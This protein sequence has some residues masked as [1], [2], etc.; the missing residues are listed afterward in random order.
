[1][2][3]YLID[4][5]DNIIEECKKKEYVV[6]CKGSLTIGYIKHCFTKKQLL[7][8]M[9]DHELWE[10][11]VYKIKDEVKINKIFEIEE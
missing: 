6:Y 11:D 2:I 1:M 4:G 10:M 5:I 7:Q 9:K 3:R 8:F